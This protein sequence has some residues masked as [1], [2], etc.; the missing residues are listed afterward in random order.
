MLHKPKPDIDDIEIYDQFLNA[1][2]VVDRGGEQVR[3]QV[4]KENVLTPANLSDGNIPTR[5]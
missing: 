4:E 1:E 2:F 3:A 5:C